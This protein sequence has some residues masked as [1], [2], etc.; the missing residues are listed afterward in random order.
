MPGRVQHYIANWCWEDIEI[1][2]FL[3]IK[4]EIRSTI[5]AAQVSQKGIL[6]GGKT[7]LPLGFFDS[8]SHLVLSLQFLYS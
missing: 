6:L 3:V 4:F 7:F 2:E 1:A 5:M 8:I